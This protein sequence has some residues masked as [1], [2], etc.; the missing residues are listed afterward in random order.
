M[1]TI[2]R[3]SIEISVRGMP[4]K[5]TRRYAPYESCLPEAAVYEWFETFALAVGASLIPALVAAGVIYFF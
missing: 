2:T 4:I 5:R 3:E 1:A